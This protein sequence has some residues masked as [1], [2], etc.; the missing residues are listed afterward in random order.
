MKLFF[1]LDHIAWLR[2]AG[3]GKEPEPAVAASLAELEGASGITIHLHQDRANVQI[4]DVQVLKETLSVPL[5]LELSPSLKNKQNA[6]DL[7]PHSVTLVQEPKDVKTDRWPLNMDEKDILAP[8]IAELSEAEIVPALLIKPSIDAVRSAHRM[9]A[10]IITLDTTVYSRAKTEKEIRILTD[11]IT[12]CVRLGQKL[13]MEV[14]AAGG[15]N[16]RNI[17]DLATIKLDAVHIG[18]SIVA[19]SMLV[20]VARAVKDMI[21]RMEKR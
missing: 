10:R 15:I 20:G 19:R 14:H 1:K 13:G 17:S 6:F 9:R 16:Y 21:S 18:Y 3:G 12:D 11:S 7:R 5:N 8:M 2:F 4:R